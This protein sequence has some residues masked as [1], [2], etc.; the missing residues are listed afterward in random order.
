[1]GWGGDAVAQRKK[2]KRKMKF[3][4]GSTII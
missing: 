2:K 3:W 4:R 1:M